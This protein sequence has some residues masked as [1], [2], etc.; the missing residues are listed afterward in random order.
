MECPVREVAAFKSPPM[1]LRG[2]YNFFIC[3]GPAISLLLDR[4]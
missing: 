1:I 2:P 4:C 3:E